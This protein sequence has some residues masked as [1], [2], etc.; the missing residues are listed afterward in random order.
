MRKGEPLAETVQYR[1]AQSSRRS[2]QS[3]TT[4]TG[5]VSMLSSTSKGQPGCSDQAPLGQPC[6]TDCYSAPVSIARS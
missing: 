2:Y 4:F 5:I 1:R 3:I 6:D